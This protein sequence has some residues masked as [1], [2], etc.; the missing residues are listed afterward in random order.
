MNTILREGRSGDGY[1]ISIHNGK[2]LGI[3]EKEKQRLGPMS[4]G[5]KQEH[6]R[7]S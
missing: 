7:A 4:C 2:G 1:S 6:L 5:Q 3:Q